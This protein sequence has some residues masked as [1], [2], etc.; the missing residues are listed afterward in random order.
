MQVKIKVVLSTRWETIKLSA[1]TL[2]Q[3]YCNPVII[4]IQNILDKQKYS[5][6]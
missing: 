5:H 3:P 4:L 1:E 6:I 2:L